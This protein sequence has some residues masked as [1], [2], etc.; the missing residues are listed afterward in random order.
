M[1]R[2]LSIL[3]EEFAIAM[4]VCLALLALSEGLAAVVFS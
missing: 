4:A 3:A 2:L 1:N